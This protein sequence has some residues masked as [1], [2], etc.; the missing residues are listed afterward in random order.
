MRS[1][2]GFLGVQSEAEVVRRG[3]LRLR[4]FWHSEHKIK[5]VVKM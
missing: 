1:C 5:S 4:W 2:S 3:K